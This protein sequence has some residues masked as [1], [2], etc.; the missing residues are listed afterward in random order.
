MNDKFENQKEKLISI[1][2]EI[3]L[4]YQQVNYLLRNEK[5]LELLD[6]DVLMN[7]THTLYDQLCAINLGEEPDNDD[8]PF[9]ADALSGIFG[10][11]M[12]EDEAN[13][14]AAPAEE[15]PTEAQE[16]ITTEELFGMP[17]EETP[18][19]VTEDPAEETI[20]EVEETV[21]EV[22]MEP[23][24]ETIEE[25]T[26]KPAEETIEEIA[27]EPVEETPTKERME[28]VSTETVEETIEEVN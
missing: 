21:A 7:R 27:F 28:E 26:E 9:D 15:S 17:Q 16:E 12:Q 6:L 18:I 25:I 8:L 3:S 4:L 13:P 22:P 10:G 11:M 24:E 1:K 19:E 20:G 23:F 2:H 5:P 14:E